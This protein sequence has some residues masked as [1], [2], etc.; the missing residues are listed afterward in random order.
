MKNDVKDK[1]KEKDK[2]KSKQGAATSEKKK[3]IKADTCEVSA[4]TV[5]IAIESPNALLVRMRKEDVLGI[6]NR[7]EYLVITKAGKSC[8]Q[9]ARE[10]IQATRNCIRVYTEMYDLGSEPLQHFESVVKILRQG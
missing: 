5:N 2:K 6:I 1:D 8:T 3:V 9:D 4:E 7:M 10:L